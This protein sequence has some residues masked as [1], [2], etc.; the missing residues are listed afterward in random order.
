ME[1]KRILWITL[2]SGFFLLVVIG[3]AALFFHSTNKGTGIQDVS[4]WTAPPV[5]NTNLTPEPYSQGIA[6]AVTSPSESAATSS[7]TR[8][9]ETQGLGGITQTDSL[10]VIANGTTNI[11]GVNEGE[12]GSTTTI[13]LNMLKNSA[14]SG[15]ATSQNEAVTAQNQAASQ[16]MQAASGTGATQTASSSATTTTS[17]A[18]SGS[19]ST[20]STSSSS[21]AKTTSSK[22]STTTKTTTTKTTSTTKT[23]TTVADRFWVQAASYS[24]KKKAD[25]ARSVLDK[26]GIQCEVFTYTDAKGTLFY[27]VRVGPYTT[28]S[29]AEYW[30]QRIDAIELF[31]GNST[32]ITNSSAPA[33]K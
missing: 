26:N 27:R 33:A 20:S 24:S 5:Q 22:S 2:A 10:T 15:S 30:K 21:S 18:S 4:V 28:K 32:Y 7:A 25:E 31:A 6:S 14:S 17:S 29:E 1:Q 13:D 11:Y 16:A 23:T 3:A 12:Q 8:T 19:A 9:A